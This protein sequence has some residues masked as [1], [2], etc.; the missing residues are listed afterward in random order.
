MLRTLV[1]GLGLEFGA[2][3][4]FGVWPE[5]ENV[6]IPLVFIGAAMICYALLFPERTKS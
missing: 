1:C 3:V 2:F 4:A 5:T 6:S